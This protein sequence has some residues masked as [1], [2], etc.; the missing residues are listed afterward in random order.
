MS[1]FKRKDSSFWWLKLCHNG[2]TIQRSTG[3]EDKLRAQEYHDRL[4][5]ELWEQARLGTKPRR[6]WQDAVLRWLAS[7]PTARTW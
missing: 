5:V 1:L 6:S 4:K 7:A 3:T 2:Q